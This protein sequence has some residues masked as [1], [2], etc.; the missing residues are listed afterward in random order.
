MTKNKFKLIIILIF[1]GIF[2]YLINDF[3]GFPEYLSVTK[4]SSSSSKRRPFNEIEEW[5][6][7]N[8]LDLKYINLT[9]FEVW[10]K[11][12][13]TKFIL[14]EVPEAWCGGLANQ[15]WSLAVLYVWGLQINRYPGFVNNT[16]WTCIGKPNEM[17]ETFPVVY[18]FFEIFVE[19]F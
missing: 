4:Y 12:K 19:V 5:Q 18:K 11:Q 2:I 1:F 17:E 15:I 6:K 3:V 14:I 8:N 10:R 7:Q 9:K 13:T 16:A